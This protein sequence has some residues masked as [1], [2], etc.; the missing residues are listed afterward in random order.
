MVKDPLT[1]WEGMFPYDALSKANISP[2]STMEEIRDGPFI[3]L[4]KGE[5]TPEVRQAWDELRFAESR[6]VVD[7][8]LYRISLSQEIARLRE[9]L[10]ELLLAEDT[11]PYVVSSAP[12][13]FEEELRGINR[14]FREI[15]FNSEEID[16]LS[17]LPRIDASS[18]FFEDG[19][20]KFDR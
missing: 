4:E 19:L 18:R 10:D 17:I 11:R 2:D 7:F 12:A 16:I 20:I 9:T 8:F 6:L 5:M 14:E 1:R 15:P 13:G 3:L